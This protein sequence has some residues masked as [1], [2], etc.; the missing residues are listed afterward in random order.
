MTLVII[1]EGGIPRLTSVKKI[2]NY[3]GLLTYPY[4]VRYS[5][6]GLRY[7]CLIIKQI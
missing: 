2:L 7:L 6:Q 1:E 5:R 3:A 4:L